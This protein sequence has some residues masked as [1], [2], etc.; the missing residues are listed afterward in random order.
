MIA[1]I[2]SSF[3]RSNI[4]LVFFFILILSEFIGIQSVLYAL[5]ALNPPSSC[6]GGDICLIQPSVAVVDSKNQFVVDFIGSAYVNMGASP[7][8]F[9]SLYL[10]QCDEKSCGTR[11]I[12]AIA[13]VPFV[14]GIA[15]FKV[16]YTYN[17]IF[18]LYF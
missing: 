17:Y 16:I 5:R 10:G 9:E 3:R 6:K 18:T 12:G 4:V 8:G 7:S 13:I 2:H 1:L 14:N 11:V 15:T